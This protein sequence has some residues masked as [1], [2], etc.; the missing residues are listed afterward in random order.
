[1]SNT[2]ST[3]DSVTTYRE[4]QLAVDDRREAGRVQRGGQRELG[5]VV[6]AEDDLE[7]GHSTRG[8]AADWGS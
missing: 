6:G 5:R 8:E 7:Q 4:R 2:E 1:M 3:S